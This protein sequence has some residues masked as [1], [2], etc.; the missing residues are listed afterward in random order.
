V[1]DPR[2]S[3][4]LL[5]AIERDLQPVRPLAR[6][7]L[8]ALLLLPLGLAVLVGVPWFWGFR[9]N[10][11]QL[12]PS[13]TWGLSALQT[14]AG[15]AIVGVA[16]REGIPG[17]KLS[18]AALTATVALAVALLASVTWLSEARAPGLVPAALRLRYIWECLGVATV[19]GIPVLAASAW[20]AWRLMPNRPW[21]AGGL[22]GLGAGLITDA[23][24]R[25]YCQA[26]DPAHVAWS[27]DGAILL[28]MLAGAAISR[29]IE[30][31]QAR[32]G[33]SLSAR[34]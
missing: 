22:Y 23:G 5:R 10:L 25:L 3:E 15:L 19:S 14:L 31:V 1:A 33:S 7:W 2:P 16:L 32:T 8:R 6:P 24:V 27:H 9:N 21:I 12:G 28:L 17:R 34:E 11:A 4:P 29:G 13:L 30:A 20:L 26:S 18:P